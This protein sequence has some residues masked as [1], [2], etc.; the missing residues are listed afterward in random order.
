MSTHT[1]HNTHTHYCFILFFKLSHISYMYT[2]MN[3][4]ILN[5]SSSPS[6]RDHHPTGQP[7]TPSHQTATTPNADLAPPATYRGA[8][9]AA[10]PLLHLSEAQSAV[11]GIASSHA[12]ATNLFCLESPSRQC[13]SRLIGVPEMET[14]INILSFSL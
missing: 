8:A 13:A 6:R 2:R 11:A 14:T 12:A 7:T 1:A 4:F 9:V 3:S 10:L 5:L